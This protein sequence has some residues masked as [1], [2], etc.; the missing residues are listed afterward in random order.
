MGERRHHEFLQGSSPQDA[1][2]RTQAS[3][4]LLAGTNVDPGLWKSRLDGDWIL[5]LTNHF[6]FESSRRASS[7]DTYL[8]CR[9]T[10][11]VNPV[12]PPSPLRLSLRPSLLS[13]LDPWQSRIS[14]IQTPLP[15]HVGWKRGH[16]HSSFCVWST[17]RSCCRLLATTINRR[18]ARAAKA[19]EARSGF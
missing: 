7:T 16:S 2:D 10:A 18:F 15:K 17:L 12:K 1:H 11:I 13:R 8:P 6:D 19:L 5:Q 4:Q 3:L 9:H 14:S